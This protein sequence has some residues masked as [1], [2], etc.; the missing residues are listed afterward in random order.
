MSKKPRKKAETEAEMDMTSMIDV[1]FLLLIFFMC[2]TKFRAPEGVLRAFLPRDRGNT[3]SSP[4]VQDNCRIVL[5]PAANGETIVSA[6][7][8]VI[9]NTIISEYEE[10]YLDGGAG[11]EREVLTQHLLQR[12]D[13]YSG[14]SPTLPVIIDF[15]PLVPWKYVVDVLDILKEIQ[16]TDIGF[17]MP[18]IPLDGN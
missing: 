7:D 18:E 6:D 3:S 17:A 16:I 5:A 9:P 14:L 15:S 12:R 11:F 4:T 8:R 10:K 2:A 13:N 1:V